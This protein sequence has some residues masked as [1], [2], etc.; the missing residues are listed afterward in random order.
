MRIGER[1]YS[2]YI[3]TEWQ[4]AQAQAWGA[5]L[6]FQLASAIAVL[7][8]QDKPTNANLPVFRN[9]FIMSDTMASGIIKT[10]YKYNW[11]GSQIS[12]GLIVSLRL[13]RWYKKHTGNC[14][15]SLREHGTSLTEFAFRSIFAALQFQPSG[16]TYVCVRLKSMADFPW[17]TL[18]I[19]L[20]VVLPCILIRSKFFF[21]QQMHSLLKHKMLHLKCLSIW[22]LHVSVH[23]DH[24]Q[25]AYDGT[26]LKLQSL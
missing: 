1:W 19:F 26:L 13:Q 2:L 15:M 20:I 3:V 9:V 21:F 18:Y 17:N 14:V 12:L 16:R 7:P 6:H 23:S 11:R 5:R 22:L 10:T 4:T 8:T 24:H 25:A